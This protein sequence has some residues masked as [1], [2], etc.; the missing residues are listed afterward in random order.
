MITNNIKL[1]EPKYLIILIK[2]FLGHIFINFDKCVFVLS[3]FLKKCSVHPNCI[4]A[5]KDNNKYII[6]KY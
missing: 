4:E 1:P 3:F 2:F 5:V 6:L